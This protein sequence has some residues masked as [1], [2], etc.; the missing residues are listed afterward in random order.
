MRDDQWKWKSALDR[1][2]IGE[3][4]EHI[5][6]AEAALFGRRAESPEE[7]S[8]ANEGEGHPIWQQGREGPGIDEAQGRRVARG[9]RESDRLAESQYSRIRQRACHEETRP[10]DRIDEERVGGEDVPDRELRFAELHSRLENGAALVVLS[11]LS[12]HVRRGRDL[13]V[14][15]LQ[16]RASPR[17]RVLLRI[18]TGA[19]EN[20]PSR[21]FPYVRH[22]GWYDQRA[23]PRQRRKLDYLRSSPIAS[24]VLQRR[25]SDVLC[26]ARIRWSRARGVGI[27]RSVPMAVVQ[28]FG[29]GTDRAYPRQTAPW[30]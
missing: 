19:G 28:A 2:S 11:P 5:V 30:S 7:G 12:A 23:M 20:H 22:G 25:H 1:W 9:N 27:S 10:E 18:A 29:I 24:I 21:T 16:L 17:A 14:S 3:T 13:P 15:W 26:S 8:E 4:A 6:M